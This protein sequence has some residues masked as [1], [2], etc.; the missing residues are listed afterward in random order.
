MKKW[1]VGLISGFVL[2]V[3]TTKAEVTNAVSVVASATLTHSNSFSDVLYQD[4]HNKDLSYTDPQI[5]HLASLIKTP[6]QMKRE[7]ECYVHFPI[8]N[9]DRLVYQDHTDALR[10]NNVNCI[11]GV[12]GM[13]K[14]CVFGWNIRSSSART[15]TNPVRSSLGTGIAFNY[16]SFQ[17]WDD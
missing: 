1:I 15:I 12:P 16:G 8:V 4:M 13:P 2:V 5:I 11:L 14:G 3:A 6:C 17:V 7:Q 9:W 10:V